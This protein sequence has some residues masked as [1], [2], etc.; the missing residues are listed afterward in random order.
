MVTR[1]SAISILF[2]LAIVH[3]T[4]FWTLGCH[5]LNESMTCCITFL[6]SSSLLQVLQL[7]VVVAGRVPGRMYYAGV[8]G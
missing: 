4:G 2:R 6:S 1:L 3:D 8:M 5:M 7:Q